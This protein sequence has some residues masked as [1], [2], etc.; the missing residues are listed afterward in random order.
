VRWIVIAVVV[1]IFAAGLVALRRAAGSWRGAA[2]R[3]VRPPAEALFFVPIALVLVGVAATGNPMV[4][5]AIRAIAICGAAIG[6]LSGAILDG[7][8]GRIGPLRAVVH[9]LL[10][11]LAVAACAYLVLDR[12]RMLDL[13]AET[14]REGPAPR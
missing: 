11:A 6:W 13:V 14:W 5:R 10:A 3:L 1:A 2:R 12:D 8:H 4:A 7:R 9:A